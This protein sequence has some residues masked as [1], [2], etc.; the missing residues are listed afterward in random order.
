MIIKVQSKTIADECIVK[1]IDFSGKNHKVELFLEA[2]VDIICSKC[3]QFG[4]NSYKTCLEQPKCFI[5]KEKHKAKDHKCF[6]K[7]YIILIGKKCS[8]TSSKYINYDG[9]H[10]ANFSYYLKRLELLNKQRLV[11]KELY[12]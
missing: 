6:I 5:Y 11:K 3:S 7:D 12:N 8:R 1:G 2:R 9:P 10:L 4:H